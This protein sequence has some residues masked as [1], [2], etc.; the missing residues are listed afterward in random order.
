MTKKTELYAKATKMSLEN[1]EQWIKD[2]KLLINNSSFGH[3]SALLRFACEE[4]AKAHICW[5][6]SEKIFPLNNVLVEEVFCYHWAKNQ[7]IFGLLLDIHLIFD[8]REKGE[9]TIRDFEQLKNLVADFNE[10]L[11]DIVFSM[12]EMRQKA[13]YVDLDEEMKG[14]ISPLE[15]TEDKVKDVLEIAKL[16]L[17]IEKTVVEKTSDEFK[18]LFRQMYS[19]L[20]KEVWETGGISIQWIENNYPK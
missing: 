3:A 17:K 20:P 7:V 13:M 14:V 6:T 1:A 11:D 9:I 10:Q 8:K 15:I 2:A 5:L 19:A 12:N 4:I 16:L 18:E